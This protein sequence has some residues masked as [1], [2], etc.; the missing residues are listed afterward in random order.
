MPVG[1]G[2]GPVGEGAVTVGRP[3]GSLGSVVPTAGLDEASAPREWIQYAAVVPAAAL[4]SAPSAT[5]TRPVPFLL[6]LACCS[7]LS[8]GVASLGGHGE[9]QAS[10]SQARMIPRSS[11]S[12]RSSRCGAIPASPRGT[13]VGEPGCQLLEL[14]ADQ[15]LQRPE[16]AVGQVLEATATGGN[17][18]LGGRE[19]LD[20]AEQ[21]LVVLRELDLHRARQARLTGQGERRLPAIA[22]GVDERR[23]AESFEP[24][25]HRAAIPAE[26]SRRRLHVEAMP[27]KAAQDRGVVGG[28]R[29]SRALRRQPEILHAEHGSGSQGDSLLE[30]VTELAHVAGPWIA[31]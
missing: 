11:V 1:I 29:A 5:A 2:S 8:I 18:G 31:L 15:G 25:S 9:Q 23:K 10:H 7:R 6:V 17:G 27:A 13:R 16:V 20:R 22:A 19:T 3:I 28:R 21:V 14:L 4:I 24:L 12:S 30:A 26:R